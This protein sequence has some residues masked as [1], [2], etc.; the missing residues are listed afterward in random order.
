MF[1]SSVHYPVGSS[2]KHLVADATVEVIKIGLTISC[3]VF[4]NQEE[5]VCSR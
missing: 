5:K 3:P 2:I 4:D 1:A